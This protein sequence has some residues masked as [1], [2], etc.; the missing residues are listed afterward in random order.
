[1]DAAS[2]QGAPPDRG[3]RRRPAPV[4]GQT[5]C[6]PSP[7]CSTSTSPGTST[8]SPPSATQFPARDGT[9]QV[10]LRAGPSTPSAHTDG[11]YVEVGRADGVPADARRAA[12]RRG[13]PQAMRFYRF[14]EWGPLVGRKRRRP[15]RRTGSLTTAVASDRCRRLHTRWTVARARCWPTS[16]VSCAP[17][18]E[19][20]RPVDDA[21]NGTMAAGPTCIAGT[22]G[23]PD[24]ATMVPRMVLPDGDNRIEL[25]SVTARRRTRCS[26]HQPGP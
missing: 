7:T 15:H 5:S 14:G 9:R 21:V 11:P 12:G 10:L 19:R 24:W 2:R 4:G 25:Y 20:R 26:P 6:P 22:V 23:A 1:M 16:R 3:H 18:R 13:Q 17:A 8:G